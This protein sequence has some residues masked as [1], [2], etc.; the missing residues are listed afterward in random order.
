MHSAVHSLQAYAKDIPPTSRPADE[1]AP[2]APRRGRPRAARD[3]PRDRDARLRG[4]LGAAGQALRPGA[5]LRPA[6]PG[7]G[8]GR[9]HGVDAAGASGSLTPVEQDEVPADTALETVL[10]PPDHVARRRVRVCGSRG[11][12]GAPADRRP[13]AADRPQR[14]RAGYAAEHPDPG[15]ADRRGRDAHRV[16]VLRAAA[17][18]PRRRAVGPGVTGPGARPPRSVAQHPRELTKTDGT[19]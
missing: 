2:A 17:A 4:R 19:R 1:R 12:V 5:H 10:E 7:A 16:D 18:G 9:R 8:P 6:G 13:G 15:G 3:G 11:A 14:G